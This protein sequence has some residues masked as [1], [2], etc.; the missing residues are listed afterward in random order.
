MLDNKNLFWCSNC[1]NMS[2]RPRI[3]FDRLGQ[4]NACLWSEKKNL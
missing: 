2:T 3:S 4:C 1:L